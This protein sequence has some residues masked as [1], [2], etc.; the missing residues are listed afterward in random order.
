[1]DTQAA[2]EKYQKM[3]NDEAKLSLYEKEILPAFSKLSENL[4]FVYGFKSPFLSFDELKADCISFLYE[5]IHKW[6]PERGTKAFSYYNVVAKNWLIINCRQHKKIKSRHVSVDDPYGMTSTQKELFESH[7]IDPAP[8][9][10]LIKRQQRT[11][12]MKL[13]DEMKVKLT[14][15]NE[16]ICLQAIETLFSNIENLEL[17]NKR[18]VLIY[19]R[20]IS[21]LDKKQLSKAMSVIR[22]HYRSMN[23]KTDS[24]DLFF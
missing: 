23:G 17:L 16:L 10:T 8:D 9:E 6:S 19:I 5:S 14:N 2:I 21:G 24:Y 20:D 12:I 18:A 15:H 11:Q 3:D 7:A 1:M 4:I 22:R 13:L